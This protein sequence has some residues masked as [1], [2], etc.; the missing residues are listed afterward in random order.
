MFKFPIMKRHEVL[1]KCIGILPCWRRENND[2]AS[3]CLAV[4]QG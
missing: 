3:S 2:R 4:P 1:M